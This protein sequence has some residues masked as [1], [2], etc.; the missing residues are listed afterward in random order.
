MGDASSTRRVSF[1]SA[2]LPQV[3]RRDGV[4]SGR[5]AHRLAPG[6][7]RARLCRAAR[8]ADP[9]GVS[10]GASRAL[11]LDD[12]DAGQRLS[13]LDRQRGPA[14]VVRALYPADLLPKNKSLRNRGRGPYVFAWTIAFVLAAHL[15]AV[16]WHA[17]IKRD[18]ILTR[19][20]PRYRPA[21]PTAKI[22]P[23]A[24]GAGH[25]MGRP[26]RP[27]E[28]VGQRLPDVSATS[29]A[30]SVFHVERTTGDKTTPTPTR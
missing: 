28:R 3:D 30:G 21:P 14:S 9:C 22:L 29:E 5:A 11:C 20:W 2:V 15:G 13:V 16:V 18:T 4:W 25:G 8:E 17:A 10:R 6:R 23:L 12:R 26:D 27:R 24:S 1:R 19:M 7:R